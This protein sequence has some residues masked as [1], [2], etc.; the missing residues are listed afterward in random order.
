MQSRLTSSVHDDTERPWWPYLMMVHRLVLFFVWQV[1]IAGILALAGEPEPFRAAA[2]WWPLTVTLTN[3]VSLAL[4]RNLS[5][6][7]GLS[8]S[9][10]IHADFSRKHLRKDLL[11]L[12]GILVVAGPIAMLPNFGLAALLFGGIETPMALFI[13]PMHA[14]LALA[15]IVLF[16][17][18]QGLAELPTYFGYVMPRLASRWSSPWW[19]VAVAAFWLGAQHMTIPFIADWR[20]LLWR[21]GMF[22]PFAVLLGVTIRWRPRLLPYLMVIHVL[23]DIQPAVAVWLASVAG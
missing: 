22:I 6:R 23:I 3:L 15:C 4:L 11:A 21:L 14:G 12:L 13:Q 10:F 1:L 18:T 17:L 20:F 19:A 9:Q 5:R 16:P 7:E 2:G 8:W